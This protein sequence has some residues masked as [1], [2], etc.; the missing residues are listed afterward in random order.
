MAV[1]SISA[2]RSMTLSRQPL[3]PAIVPERRLRDAALVPFGVLHHDVEVA[4]IVTR[5]DE[6]CTKLHEPC[7]LSLHA[8]GSFTGGHFS[9]NPDVQMDAVLRDLRL[10]HGV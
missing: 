2:D 10:G 3:I 9:R 6:G 1:P 4:V 8:L 5:P 7:R